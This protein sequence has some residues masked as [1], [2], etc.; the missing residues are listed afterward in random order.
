M[1]L[2]IEGVLADLGIDILRVTGDEL[3]AKC[4]QHFNRTGKEDSRPSWS[5]NSASLAHHCFS[6]GYSGGLSSLYR[7]MTGG[8]P[9]DLT[10]EIAKS[11]VISKVIE[12]TVVEEPKGPAVNEWML[13]HFADMPDKLLRIRQLT[14]TSIDAFQ[15]RWD[16]ERRMWVIP[17]RSP[18][19]D[20]WG[21]QFRQKG[22]VLNHPPG[23]TKGRTLFGLHLLSE[24]RAMVVE[25]PLDVIRLHGLGIPAVATFGASIS[26]EQLTLLSRNLRII[27]AAMDN[28]PAGSAANRR[29][30]YL[31]SRCVVLPFDY[32]GLE[33]KDPGDIE[34]DGDILR[35]W[36][37]ALALRLHSV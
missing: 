10:W 37:K 34:D 24:D 28:D 35:C 5:I 8:V 33:A 23:M 14:R 29:L 19:G 26:D 9:E 22:K 32:L 17:V 36:S 1:S 6:C 15:V 2:D 20:L 30:Q 4:P 11:S 21:Y 31:K 25:S 13:T 3:V 27:V 18:K 16:A 12:R 7:D